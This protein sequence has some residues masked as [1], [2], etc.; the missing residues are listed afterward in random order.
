MRSNSLIPNFCIEGK[1]A[2]GACL[3]SNTAERPVDK[4]TTPSQNNPGVR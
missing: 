3:M 2:Q 1:V 4:V